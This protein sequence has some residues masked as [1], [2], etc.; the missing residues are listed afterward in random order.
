VS[1]TTDTIKLTLAGLK[2]G[3]QTRILCPACGGGASKEVSMLVSMD[4]S[5][6]GGRWRCFRNKCGVAGFTGDVRHSPALRAREPTRKARPYQGSLRDLTESEQGF[7]RERIGW[8]ASHLRRAR[9]LYA[10]DDGRFALPILAA[11]G[12]R[13]G[14]V[15]RSWTAT[16]KTLTRMDVIEPHL[17]FYPGPQGAEWILVVEDIPSAVRAAEY[18]HAVALLGTGCSSEYAAEI[19]NFCPQV[20]W[21]LDADATAQ[22]VRLKR[23]H[24]LMFDESRQLVLRRD[25]KDMGEGD[26]AQLLRDYT[27]EGPNARTHT[28]GGHSGFT[29]SDYRACRMG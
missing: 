3:E 17:S 16:P 21:C 2:P 13:R 8:R 23:Q 14:Y 4:A 9:P 15:L 1:A 24:G 22:A 25:I 7:L 12:R 18:C 10:P 29:A 11:S 5:G 19:A 6:S 28:P 20:I 27:P 26:V